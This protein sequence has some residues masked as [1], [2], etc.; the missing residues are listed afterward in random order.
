MMQRTVIS[1]VGLLLGCLL[2]LEACKKQGTAAAPLVP[3]QFIVPP[4]FPDPVYKFENNTPSRQGFELGKKLFYDGRLSQDGNFP[5]ASCHQQFAA[6]ATFDHPLSHGFNNQFT[7]RNAPG[8]FNVAWMKEL[9]WD[10]GINHIEVQPLAPLIAE[11]EMAETMD[12]VIAK[13]QDDAA[14]RQMFKTV[15]GD[16]EISPQKMLKALTQ[17]VAMLVS[18]DSKYDKV[19]R[20]TA[21]FTETEEAGYQVFQAKCAACHAEPLFTDNSFRNT[22]LPVNDILKDIGR[23]HITGNPADSLKFKVPSLRNVYATF[24]YGHDGRFYSIGAVIDHY[25][26]G[27]VSGPTTD[28]LVKNKITISDYEK[29][30][31]LEFLR[32]LTDSAFINNKNFAQTE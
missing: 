1:L 9:H 16:E 8:L 22:G 13:L 26:F 14:Y 4:E 19:K 31:L 2:F 15:F 3:L 20:G 30:D 32:T 17:F 25:R 10:G 18:A 21:S 11:N 24:P 23:M 12:H 7:T 28:L 5:C 27:V 29:L 6:F